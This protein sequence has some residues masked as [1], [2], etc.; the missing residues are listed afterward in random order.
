MFLSLFNSFVSVKAPPDIVGLQDPPV[1]G[2]RLP[3]FG[4]FTLLHA[5][6]VGNRKPRVALYVS[7]ALWAYATILP[8]FFDCFDV[9]ALD[10]HGSDLF[11][12]IFPQFRILNVYNLRSNSVNCMTVSPVVSFPEIHFPL[13]VVGDFNI[14][15]PLSDSLRAHSAEEL[16]V[17]FPYFSRAA[18]MGYEL[19]KT[20]RVFTWFPLGGNTCPSVIDLSFA[21]P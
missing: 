12:R 19:L 4:G 8:L 16:N 5:P 3:T 10:F 20:P 13:L 9:A 2:S 17:S 11:V 21:S 18:R 6:T 14:H 15:H 7:S 1:W